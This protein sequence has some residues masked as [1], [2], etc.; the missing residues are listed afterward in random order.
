MVCEV[1]LE[2]KGKALRDGTRPGRSN[3]DLKSKAR[4]QKQAVCQ[5]LRTVARGGPRGLLSHV[6]FVIREVA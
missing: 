3:T 6:Q 5:G 1:I 4:L 2:A